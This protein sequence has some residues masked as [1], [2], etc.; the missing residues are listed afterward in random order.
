MFIVLKGYKKGEE[1]S[2]KSSSQ[3]GRTFL[4]LL[5]VLVIMVLITMLGIG[6]YQSAIKGQQADRDYEDIQLYICQICLFFQ[7][8]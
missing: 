5:G 4:E 8:Y 3:S 6:L 7:S 2:C 1:M